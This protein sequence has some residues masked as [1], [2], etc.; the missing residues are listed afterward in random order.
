MKAQPTSHPTP[1]PE[2]LFREE[3]FEGRTAL[4]HNFACG[5]HWHP[6]TSI[7]ELLTKRQPRCLLERIL[8]EWAS[9]PPTEPEGGAGR[10]VGRV[11]DP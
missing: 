11:D 7:S 4:P 2:G 3:E 9:F 6:I 10:E 8:L 1:P 5:D